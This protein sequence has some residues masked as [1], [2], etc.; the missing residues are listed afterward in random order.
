MAVI[1]AAGVL[2]SSGAIEEIQNAESALRTGISPEVLHTIRTT[3]IYRTEVLISQCFS[4]ESVQRARNATKA[5][6][7]LADSHFSNFTG[8]DLATLTLLIR[9]SRDDTAAEAAA[10][11]Q[12]IVE[13]MKEMGPHLKTAFLQILP[14][15]ICQ[16]VAAACE[17]EHRSC[18]QEFVW[19]ALINSGEV[20]MQLFE[21]GD[22]V[23]GIARTN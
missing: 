12:M 5:L 13:R 2:C 14:P 4:F 23:R 1:F 18:L 19:L 17:P 9:C 22:N 10:T 11:L 16:T 8:D 20:E 15:I 3:V 6:R 21:S 7:A